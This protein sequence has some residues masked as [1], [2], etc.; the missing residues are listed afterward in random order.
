LELS[1]PE[2]LDCAGV[3]VRFG[4][5]K[6][7]NGANLQVAA[8]EIVAILGRSGSG[9]TT[10]L[11]AIAGFERRSRRI[12]SVAARSSTSVS[13]PATSAPWPSSITRSS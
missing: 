10:L 5:L 8:G 1:N 6:A 2:P 12:G 7:V 3:E 11:R 4:S 9:K 13:V